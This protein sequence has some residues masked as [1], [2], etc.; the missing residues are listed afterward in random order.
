MS[1]SN[2]DYLISILEKIDAVKQSKEIDGE[3]IN[4]NKKQTHSFNLEMHEELKAN[5]NV[6]E[7]Y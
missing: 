7:Q 1:T 2:T 4:E 3:K 5:K 6:I